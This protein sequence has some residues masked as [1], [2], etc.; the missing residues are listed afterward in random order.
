MLCNNV[1]ILDKVVG[2]YAAILKYSVFERYVTSTKTESW[3]F[4]YWE[5]VHIVSNRLYNKLI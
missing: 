1:V 2:K 3:V 4:I 5:I